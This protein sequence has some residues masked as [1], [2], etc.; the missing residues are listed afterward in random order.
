MPKKRDL[1]GMRFG[2]LVV[3]REAPPTYNGRG[4]RI[5]RWYCDCD[6]G[7][8]DHI[9]RGCNLP[10]AKSCGCERYL[11]LVGK[12]FGRLEVIS[13]L[14]E[15]TKNNLKIFHCKCDCGNECDVIG[16]YL[17][18]G[19]TKSCGCYQKDLTRERFHKTN[20]YDLTNDYGIGYTTKGEPFYFD[21]EDYD[22]IKDYCWY[23]ANSGYLSAKEGNGSQ[24]HILMHN[25]IMGQ[26]YIDHINGERNDNR[27]ENLRIPEGKYSFD[28]Y[29]QMNKGLQSNNTSGTTGVTWH[30]R[31]GVWEVYISINKKQIYLGRYLDIEDAIQARKEAEKK[32]FG[33]YSY[34]N[35]QLS[36]AKIS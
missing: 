3:T 15:R 16:T 8:K 26:K 11:N 28:S 10:G 27:K 5:V 19:N 32:Y 22:K 35:S 13:E 33:E 30:K 1:T 25:L 36:V 17:V 18:N 14:S 12:R 2:M 20:K 9:V 21:L 31:D 4:H 24:K 6:C 7:T 23:I 34:D 29:N